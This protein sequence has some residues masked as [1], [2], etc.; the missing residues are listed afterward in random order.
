MAIDFIEETDAPSFD[1]QPDPE[2]QRAAPVQPP[3]SR[4]LS[5]EFMRQLGL[6]ARAGYQ[7]ITGSAQL[8]ADPLVMGAN[9][10]FG[11]N[12]PLPSKATEQTLNR[13][14]PQPETPMEKGVG[15]GAQMVAGGMDPLFGALQSHLKKLTP[16]PL[17]VERGLE[18]AQRSSAKGETIEALRAN[19]IKLTPS[20]LE[21]GPVSRTFAGLSGN[22]RMEA[23]NR[24]SNSA[25]LPKMA[26]KELGLPPETHLTTQV[27]KSQADALIDEGY[28]PLRDI[29]TPMNTGGT[30][31]NALIRL[32]NEFG[33]Q[34]SLPAVAR[35]ANEEISQYLFDP[36]LGLN[37]YGMPRPRQNFNTADAMDNIRQL[38]ETAR[39]DFKKGGTDAIMGKVRLGIANALED[40]I[41]QNLKNNPAFRPSGSV[42]AVGPNKLD[43]TQLLEGFRR[44]R[45]GLAKNY[46]VDNMLVDEA[47]GLID[48]VK[49]FNL[50][51]SGVKLTG[52]LN[53]IAEAGS[54]VYRRS[55]G[56]PSTGNPAP[57]SVVEGGMGLL[58]AGYGMG[59][60]NIG[61]GMAAL[62]VARAGGR[63]ALLSE[64]MQNMLSRDIRGKAYIDP[65]LAAKMWGAGAGAVTPGAM[66]LFGNY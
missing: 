24:F 1:F 22:A 59:G 26:A 4:T 5:E 55:T 49:A 7:G 36:R 63:H 31:H 62:P 54:K 29:R 27:L 13:F 66:S 32:R 10:L 65:D 52:N 61:W 6:T 44:A 12:L 18:N 2:V 23:M 3:R 46:A 9:S 21:A 20:E 56:V 14:L 19:K 47:S 39:G 51:E 45:E 58:G 38:R 60:G 15:I 25:E 53:L 43:R 37:R 11:S 42:A 33:G 30:F 48:P 34:G 17:V 50:R 57:V 16:Q 41:E 28:A 40:S 64:P 35:E 8:L